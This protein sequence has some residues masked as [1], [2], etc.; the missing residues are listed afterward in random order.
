MNDGGLGEEYMTPRD[1]EQRVSIAIARV[2]VRG[3]SMLGKW[4]C[5]PFLSHT[6]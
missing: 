4:Q 5:Q 2:Y 6:R 1:T 3:W